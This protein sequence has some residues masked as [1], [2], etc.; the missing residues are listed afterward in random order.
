M[1]LVAVYVQRDDGTISPDPEFEEVAEIECREG[2]IALRRMFDRPEVIRGR[3]LSVDLL[4]NK[5]I[6][7]RPGEQESP[8]P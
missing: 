7:E 1:C 8:S 6:I 2:Q 4:H 5:V 3:I